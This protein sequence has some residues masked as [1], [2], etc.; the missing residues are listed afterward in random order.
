MHGRMM[1]T[2]MVMCDLLSV[3]LSVHY[4]W[5]CRSPMSNYPGRLE[6]WTQKEVGH[7]LVSTN[8]LLS[9]IQ[10]LILEADK[11]NIAVALIRIGPKKFVTY[12]Q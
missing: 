4:D 11:D 5:E 7:F 8:S 10:Q 12:P 1:S 6:P 3:G 2:R 9:D